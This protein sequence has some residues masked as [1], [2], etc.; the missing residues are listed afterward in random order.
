MLD[1]FTSVVPAE[2]LGCQSWHLQFIGEEIE[3]QKHPQGDV[4]GDPVAKPPSSQCRGPGFH[5]WS[6]N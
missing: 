5:P 6:G 1:F 3:F 2:S 4:L